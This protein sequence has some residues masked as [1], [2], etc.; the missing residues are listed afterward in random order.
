M[1]VVFSVLFSFSLAFA[2]GS[3]KDK[4]CSTNA[5]CSE[6]FAI[7]E[8]KVSEVKFVK[9]IKLIT[10]SEILKKTPNGALYAAQDKSEKWL[11]KQNPETILSQS[12][13]AICTARAGQND[14]CHAFVTIMYWHMVPVGQKTPQTPNTENTDKK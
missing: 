7:G 1:L 10:F 3:D 14:N 6:N 12:Q 2:G 13:T 5:S 4:P 9:K 8:V 11:A